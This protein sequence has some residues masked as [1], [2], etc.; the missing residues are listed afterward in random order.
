MIMKYL[1][2]NLMKNLLLL[3][4]LILNTIIRMNI[5]VPYLLLKK[6]L[7]LLLKRKHLYIEFH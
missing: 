4:S 2:E 1:Q 6:H 5:M 3:L 7:S